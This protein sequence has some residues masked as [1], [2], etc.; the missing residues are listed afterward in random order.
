MIEIWEPRY[1]DRKVLVA[2]NKVRANQDVEI[3]ITKG[4]YKGKYVV[5][6]K[7]VENSAREKMATKRGGEIEV[8]CIPLDKLKKI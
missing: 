1:R 4:F 6:Y 5:D 2:S 3:E 8:I 7:E